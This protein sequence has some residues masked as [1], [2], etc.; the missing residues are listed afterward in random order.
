VSDANLILG[1]LPADRLLGGTLKLSTDAAKVALTSLADELGTDDV[2]ALADGI[3]RLAVAKMAAAVRE[4]TVHRGH[5]PSSF[6][7]LA[8]GG[9][10]PMHAFMVADELGITS[11]V[12]PRWPGHLSAFGQLSANRRYDYLTHVKFRLSSL[13]AAALQ[14]AADAL[15]RKGTAALQDGGFPQARRSGSLSADM[16]YVGQSFTLPVPISRDRLSELELRRAHSALH[17]ETF[18]F[19]DEAGDVEIVAL[20]LVALGLAVPVS[21]HLA[22]SQPEAAEV[23]RTRLWF[24]G[25]WREARIFARERLVETQRV[26]GPALVEEAGATTVV[27]P[28]WMLSVDRIGNLMGTKDS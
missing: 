21:L 2:L 11:V 3:I 17:R 4:V 12:V 6:A 28:G 20:R 25:E 13:D 26:S 10:G 5:D 27:P 1:R 16:R 24:D 8:F 15:E 14:E 7:L 22:P 23:D 19:H 18:G 9:A